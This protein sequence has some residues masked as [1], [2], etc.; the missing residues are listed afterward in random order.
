MFLLGLQMQGAISSFP[1]S[2]GLVSF[3]TLKAFANVGVG[4]PYI[5]ARQSGYSDGVPTSPTA[6]YGWLFL[7]V[8]GL[9]NYLIVLDAF[10]IARGRKP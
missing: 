6:D 5:L 3:Q 8:A 2:G 10:D 4:L 7:I 9:L 1:E